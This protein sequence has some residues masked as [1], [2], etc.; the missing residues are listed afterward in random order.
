MHAGVMRAGVVFVD[1]I[2]NLLDSYLFPIPFTATG[3]P[4]Y[5][6]SRMVGATATAF[7]N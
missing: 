1:L 3:D 2:R 5:D 7:P 4:S 6:Q